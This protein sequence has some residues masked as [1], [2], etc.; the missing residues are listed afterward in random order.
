MAT[1][2]WPSGRSWWKL[3]CSCCMVRHVAGFHGLV[4]GPDQCV[5]EWPAHQAVIVRSSG[6]LLAMEPWDL[7]ADCGTRM[8]DGRA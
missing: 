2:W 8:R 3:R 5:Q 1:W 7:R 4:A 6:L